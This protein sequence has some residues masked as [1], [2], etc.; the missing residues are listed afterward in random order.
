MPSA[1]QTAGGAAAL[2]AALTISGPV[3][4]KWEGKVNDPYWDLAHV[5]SVCWGETRGVQERHYSDAECLAMF[6][7]SQAE[8]GREIQACLPPLVP[9]PT[10]AAFIVFAY[11]VG[12][13]NACK[14]T[15]A[16]RV[17]AGDVAGGCNALLAW[18][19]VRQVRRDANGLLVTSYVVKQG[20]ANRRA[21]ERALCLQ[22]AP[23]SIARSS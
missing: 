3:I 7:N 12:V 10:L 6:R 11:N 17:W 22:G 20:L 2:A 18:N 23:M 1:R 16:R 14:S 19:K 13:T 9:V 4:Q 5:R 21:E 8:H 15:A